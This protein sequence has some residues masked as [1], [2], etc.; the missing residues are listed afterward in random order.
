[1]IMNSCPKGQLFF[2][3]SGVFVALRV[4]CAAKT[5]IYDKCKKYVILNAGKNLRCWIYIGSSFGA[6][7]LRITPAAWLRMT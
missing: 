7:I 6:E 1:M 4:E 2:C 3:V 5:I